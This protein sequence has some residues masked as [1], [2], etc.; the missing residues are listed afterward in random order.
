M[1]TIRTS[2]SLPMRRSFRP[3]P[4]GR[5]LPVSGS[6]PHGPGCSRRIHVRTVDAVAPR[7]SPNRSARTEQRSG[8]VPTHDLEEA[9]PDQTA[10]EDQAARL[11][12]DEPEVNG[13]K[14]FA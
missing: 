12:E 2:R 11:V 4:G 1:S 14:G 7:D 13:A 8:S 5:R 9:L 3:T 10:N 6:R